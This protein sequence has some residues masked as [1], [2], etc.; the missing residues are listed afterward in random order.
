[1]S[2]IDTYL[3]VVNEMYGQIVKDETENINQIAQLLS[4][5]VIQG[6]IA[7]IFGTGH[8]EMVCKEVFTRAGSLS[9]FRIIGMN[10]KLEKFERLEGMAKIILDNYLIELG[11]LVF[12]ISSSGINSLPVEMAMLSKKMGAQVIAFT[13]LSHSK[14]VNSRHKSGKKLFEVADLVVDTHVPAGDAAVDYEGFQMRVGPVSSLANIFIINSIV[15]EATALILD[16]GKIPPIRLSRNLPGGDE[17]NQMFVEKYHQ[18][19][20]EIIL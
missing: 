13:S 14:S 5:S 11:E 6:H 16:Q 17:H 18:R 9:C 3:N 10:Y 1:M 20:P 8:S 12:V 15:I 4:K 7:H 2:Y 19:I